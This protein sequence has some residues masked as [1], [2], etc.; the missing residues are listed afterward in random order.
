MRST[1]PDTRLMLSVRSG[2]RASFDLL[3]ERHFASVARLAQRYLG[4]R[5]DADDLAQEVFL[6]V[7]RARERYR[8]EAKFSTWIYRITANL[9]LNWIRNR[10]SRR[11]VPLGSLF[12]S[13]GG[14]EDSDAASTVEDEAAAEP[15]ER[16]GELE[17]HR[18]VRRC[19]DELPDRQ[20][21]A[22]VLSKYEGLGYQEIA[23]VLDLSVVGVKS[24]L[25]RA[26]ET[27]KEK[28][29]PYVRMGT[30]PQEESR[31]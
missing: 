27:L 25:F 1:D 22:V 10:K 6:K 20:R 31:P 14:G 4:S 3:M 2:D 8:P 30:G 13:A 26:R 28:L 18:H 24:L 5:E 16:L 12:E 7:Y 19:L 29:A 21:L 9:C 11:S 23:E 15:L 17:V